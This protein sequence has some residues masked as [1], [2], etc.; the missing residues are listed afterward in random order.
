MHIE[1][2]KSCAFLLHFCSFFCFKE[3]GKPGKP[4]KPFIRLICKAGKT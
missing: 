2:S 4:D 1:N 3:M